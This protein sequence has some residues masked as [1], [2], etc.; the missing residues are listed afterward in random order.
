MVFGI[1]DTGLEQPSPMAMVATD[2]DS[3]HQVITYGRPF[4]GR[5]LFISFR[6]VSRIL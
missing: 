4:E 1:H 5:H 2:A 3:V 6:M